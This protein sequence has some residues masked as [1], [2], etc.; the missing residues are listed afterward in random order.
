MSQKV[1]VR[2]GSA[3]EIENYANKLSDH[4]KLE[5]VVSNGNI[6]QSINENGDITGNDNQ[7]LAVFKII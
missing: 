7:Y 1:I 3:R 2:E 6:K 4:Y 5:S